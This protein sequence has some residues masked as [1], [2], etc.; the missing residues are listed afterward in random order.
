[1]ATLNVDKS[2]PLESLTFPCGEFSIAFSSAFNV[3]KPMGGDVNVESLGRIS[4]DGVLNIET[5]SRI[6]VDKDLAIQILR[7]DSVFE[8]SIN[9][10]FLA[11]MTPKD[12]VIPLS[13]LGEGIPIEV[14]SWILSSRE[15]LY[16]LSY[17]TNSWDL[18][19]RNKT[20]ELLDRLNSFTQEERPG[21]WSL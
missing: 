11:T 16:T 3:C 5:L 17:R 18:V 6:G 1:M 14:L 20:M 13:F 19:D 4:S 12:S 7:E 8:R 9:I 2:I 10:E 15:N 21:D